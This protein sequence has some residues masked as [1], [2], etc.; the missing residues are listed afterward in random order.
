MANKTRNRSAKNGRFVTK[1]YAAKHKATTETET[2]RDKLA[3]M[4]KRRENPFQWLEYMRKREG[5]FF[6][7]SATNKGYIAAMTTVDGADV[8]IHAG[9]SNT[10][11]DE[12]IKTVQSK[13]SMHNLQKVIHKH[14]PSRKPKVK[15]K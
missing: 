2:M 5:Y 1:K 15:T 12:A 11:F 10:S 13:F 14:T 4:R 3:A 8:Q 9:Q 7:L 6:K